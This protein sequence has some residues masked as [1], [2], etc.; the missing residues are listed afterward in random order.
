M[1]I[2]N[3]TGAFVNFKAMRVTL[4]LDLMTEIDKMRLTKIEIVSQQND[5]CYETILE[6]FL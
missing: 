6:L 3:T 5:L 2:M 4:G 1:I